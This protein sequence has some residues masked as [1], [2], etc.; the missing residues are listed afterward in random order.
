MFQQIFVAW[1]AL[2]LPSCRLRRSTCCTLV[3]IVVWLVV[4][5]AVYCSYLSFLFSVCTCNIRIILYVFNLYI[6]YEKYYSLLSSSAAAAVDHR[7]VGPGHW[8]PNSYNAI[9]FIQR[10]QISV[11]ET[12]MCAV[13]YRLIYCVQGIPSLLL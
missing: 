7:P 5:Y 3:G 12:T 4:R 10:R 8:L 13:L 11:D 1:T 9:L 2:A 6:L